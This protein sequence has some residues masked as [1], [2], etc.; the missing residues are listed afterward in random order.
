MQRGEYNHAWYR[1]TCDETVLIPK[2]ALME[3]VQPGGR[4]KK[5]SDCLLLNPGFYIPTYEKY[6]CLCGTDVQP[7]SRG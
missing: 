6:M 4:Y 1:P 7:T 5:R 2:R 3:K